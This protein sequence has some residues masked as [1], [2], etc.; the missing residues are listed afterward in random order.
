M[1]RTVQ[2]LSV[3][4]VWCDVAQSKSLHIEKLDD[5]NLAGSPDGRSREC[6]LILTEGDSAKALAMSGLAVLGRDRYGVFPLKGK[7]MNVRDVPMHTVVKN[8]VP[9][10]LH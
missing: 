3:C 4:M 9:F 5:A 7:M 8:E 2:S 6:T 1:R 10:P